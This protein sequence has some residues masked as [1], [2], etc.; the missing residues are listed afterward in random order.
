MV[1]FVAALAVAQLPHTTWLRGSVWAVEEDVLSALWPLAQSFDSPMGYGFTGDN[2]Y[3]H[4]IQGAYGGTA[5]YPPGYPF[6]LWAAARIVGDPHRASQVIGALSAVLLMASTYWLALGWT[7]KR[8]VALVAAALLATSSAVLTLAYATSTD[9]LAGA[10][11][12]AALAGGV[13]A[14]RRPDRRRWIFLAAVA[15]G[16]GFLVRRQ[17]AVM[18]LPLLGIAVISARG[19]WREMVVRASIVLGVASL[20]A[21][22]DL[23]I[24]LQLHGNPFHSAH[25]KNI[26]NAVINRYDWPAWNDVPNTVSPIAVVAQAPGALV[27]NWMSNLLHYAETLW[28]GPATFLVLPGLVL[29][30]R[31][32]TLRT[33][34][35]VALGSALV[36]VLVASISERGD[37]HALILVPTLAVVGAAAIWYGVSSMWRVRVGGA[38]RGRRRSRRG[39]PHAAARARRAPGSPSPAGRCGAGRRRRHRG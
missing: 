9:L 10:A 37:R 1:A 24:Q 33:R 21:L 14:I 2:P 4:L 27:E 13:W 3:P 12:T 28:L 29:I 22:P 25:G 20:V 16:I 23:I 38:F 39:R 30:W 6:L 5:F 31:R 8:G 26:W 15:L 18:L 34:T 7:G 35:A 36:V 17:S 11:V 19:R 32:R